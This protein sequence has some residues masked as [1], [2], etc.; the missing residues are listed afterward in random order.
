MSGNSVP[1]IAFTLSAAALLAFTA[2][3]SADDADQ[4][5]DTNAQAS[6]P[7]GNS[8]AQPGDDTTVTE[9]ETVIDEADP[10]SLPDFSMEQQENWDYLSGLSIT[11]VRAAGNE[12]FDRI[13]IELDGPEVGWNVRYEDPPTQ[14]GSGTPI[15]H[16]GDAALMVDVIGTSYPFESE[17]PDLTTVTVSPTDTATVV[18]VSG[19]GTFEGHTQYLISVDGAEQPFRVFTLD[20][21]NRLVIDVQTTT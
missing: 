4:D 8:A 7:S 9:T 15:E 3:C 11:D 14:Q 18:E 17:A 19:H 10:E 12:G 21:P 1:R 20:D 13:V 2:A 6:D 16:P 5:V